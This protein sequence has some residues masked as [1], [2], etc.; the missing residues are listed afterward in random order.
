MLELKLIHVSKRVPL[1]QVSTQ[2]PNKNKSDV[3]NV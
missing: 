3:W 1:E 2:G